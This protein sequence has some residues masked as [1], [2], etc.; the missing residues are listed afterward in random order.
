M[1]RREIAA[2]VAVGVYILFFSMPP[3][4]IVRA[5]LDNIVG[6]G[7]LFLAAGYVT[8][9]KSKLVGGLLLL[10]LVLSVSRGGRE[11]LATQAWSADTVYN[12]GDMMTLDGKTYVA[13]YGNNH[14]G[15]TDPQFATYWKESIPITPGAPWSA[16]ADYKPMDTMTSGGKTYIA[17][18]GNNNMPPS[19][20]QFSTYWIEQP[21]PAAATPPPATTPTPGTSTTPPAATPST[22]T[23]PAPSTTST[24]A[25]CNL[26]NFTTLRRTLPQEYT[27][28]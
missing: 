8:I 10:A 16:S 5:V 17:K 24:V 7:A 26:E 19:N 28:F 12:P 20:P 14:M 18:L 9:Y 23:V 13:V 1:N 22:S 11:G 25:S 15:K 6:L 3:P 4:A 27:A 2:A 21:T